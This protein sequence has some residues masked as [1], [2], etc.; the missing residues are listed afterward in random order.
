MP[1]DDIHQ[2]TADLDKYAELTGQIPADVTRM[3][4]LDLYAELTSRNPVDTGYSRAN[5]RIGI[6]APDTTVEP[7][8]RPKR[9]AQMGVP[10]PDVSVLKSIDGTEIVFI[11][12]SVPYVE[13]LEEGSSR[14][15]PNGF[16]AISE[17][18]I[19]SK[20]DAYI[21]AAAPSMT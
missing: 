13:F 4:A 19:E 11:T 20:I 17:K 16:I 10:S 1:D 12:N 18:L 8:E 15:A 3:I 14:Q 9:G 2:F 6:G 21:A 7:T 5:W